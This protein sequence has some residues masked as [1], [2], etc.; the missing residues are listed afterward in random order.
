MHSA[1]PTGGRS[2]SR[3]SWVTLGLLTVTL[4]ACQDS[5][6]PSSNAI[7]GPSGSAAHEAQNSGGQ[8]PGEYIVVFNDDVKDIPGQAKGLVNANA[9]TLH[10]TFTDA[11]HGFSAHLSPQA[12]QAIENNPNVA[13]VEQDQTVAAAGFGGAGVQ[14]PAWEWG[15]DR[16]DQRG[17]VL[18]TSYSWMNDGA[19]VVV[20]I[21]DTGV[22]ISHQEFGGRASYG[23]DLVNGTSADDCNGHGT[24]MAGKVAG[25]YYG[26]AKGASI[27]SVRVL[28]CSGVSSASV[29][30]AGLDWVVRNHAPLSVANLSFAGG[31]SSAVNQAV[32]SAIAAGITV[33]AAAGDNGMPP[34]ACQYSP[35]SATDAITVGAM[36]PGDLMA[37]FSNYGP[38]V[39]LFAPGWQVVSAWWTGDNIVWQLDGSSS[40]AAHVSG[41]A[42]IYLAMHPSATPGDVANGIMTAST[43][44]ALGGLGAN[45]VNR[46]L[47]AGDWSSG[48]GIIPPPPPP[49][50]NT[51]PTASFTASCSRNKCSFDG[52]GSRD[53]V[54]IVSYRWAFGDGTTA[55]TTSPKTNH[56]YLAKG[57]YNMTITLTVSDAAGLTGSASKTVTIKNGK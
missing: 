5:M 3:A 41:A 22:R 40:A 31:L 34:D 50:S 36:R 26:V 43:Q 14:D 42:A 8:I 52:S 24:H 27:V 10:F 18:D 53:D 7:R 12:A 37:G 13:Y 49:P 54:G 30:V 33:V 56:S 35:S 19:G 39:D 2:S 38:C 28:D 20:Y 55:T 29:T 45:T 6:A 23:A 47:F 9:G 11:V 16:I 48:G 57:T 44:N 51:A 32:S 1:N 46:L 4:A 17:A 15:L 25:S 21:L